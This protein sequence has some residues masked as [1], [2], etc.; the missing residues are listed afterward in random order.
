M[1]RPP[2]DDQLGFRR[3]LEGLLGIPATEGNQVDVLRN[4]D[5]IFPALFEAIE[6]ATSTIDF[7]TFVYWEGSIGEELAELLAARAKAGVRVRV[8]LDAL[9]ALSMNRGLVERM[10]AAGAQ[11][12]WF[13]PV[14]KL[15][16]WEAN[17]RSHRKVLI[18]DE[19]VAF[20]GGIGIA[21]EWRGDARL[22]GEWRDT[23]FRVRGPA[24]DGLRAAFVQNWAETG[25]PLFDDGVDRFPVQ[26]QAGPSCVQVV[27]GAAQTGWS[28]VATLLRSLLAL[29]R[30]RVRI[31]TAYFVPDDATCRLLAETARRGVDVDVLLPGPHV[32]KRFVQLA[33]ES[34][35]AGLLGAGVR[36]W[37]YQVSMLH[38]KVMTVDGQVATV[39]SAN[40]TNRSMLLDDEVNLVVFDPAVVEIL[41]ADFDQDM[42]RSEAVDP[43]DW[44]DRGLA[45][46]AKEAVAGLGGR[47]M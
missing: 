36:L 26:P 11:V 38:A 3:A 8:I 10:A 2:A 16:F 27:R 46:K 7:L 17:R 33:S 19:D 37:S 45:Q 40:F 14:N 25:R 31:T 21:D 24:V 47:H 42:L 43:D 34:Q 44:T 35:Y 30:E 29:A 39:G 41:D 23:H 9:G 4:G 28:D 1:P 13:R 32:D 12:E 22:P 15:K 6:A 5:R 18:C 20:T